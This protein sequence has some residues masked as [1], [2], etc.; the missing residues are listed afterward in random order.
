[1]IFNSLQ[2]FIFLSVVSLV[3]YFSHQRFRKSV[4]IIASVIFIVSFSFSSLI[5]V[6]LSS[7]LNFYAA[8]KSKHKIW[9]YT[10]IGL[11]IFLILFFN[12]V[13]SV[14]EQL[15]V[16]FKP[17][18][19]ELNQF[20]VAIG[21]SFYT[22]Q[23]I[24]YL[25]DVRRGR[26]VAEKDFS[27]FLL[28][29]FYFPK[30]VCGPIATYQEIRPQFRFLK[31]SQQNIEG[32][33]NRMLFGYFKKI[34]LADR[35]APAVSSVFDFNDD[36]AGF[37]I[38]TAGLIF[39]MQLYF[40]FS[41]YCDIAVGVSRIFGINLIENF[42]FP[43]RSTSITDFWRKWH[44]SLIHFFTHYV[45]YPIA[46]KLRKYF[47]F[48][49]VVAIIVTFTLSSL[50]HGIGVT[51]FAWAF[52]HMTFLCV[53]LFFNQYGN[54][55]KFKSNNLVKGIQILAV[56]TLVTISNV[57]FRAPNNESI[58]HIIHQLNLPN[59]CIPK[60]WL[61]DF[62]APLAQGGHQIQLFNFYTSL[63]LVIVFLLFERR[64]FSNFNSSKLNYLSVFIMLILIF[65][66]GV[67]GNSSRFIYMQF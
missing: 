58:S 9:F 40:D 41:G 44:K 15:H 42:D 20:L 30:L 22:I 52:C 38:I 25:I 61:A 3:Y 23:H 16:F 35:L 67:F 33:I 34:V 19:F 24:A 66:F 14:S 45:Y 29:S 31:P 60:D 10:I 18:G 43:L 54:N 59:N 53:E 49:T 27:I 26:I 56:I 62:I 39:T 13:T 21:L 36:L 64:L 28:A 2:F 32:G 8:Q 55:F 46:F 51:F 4:L 7:L 11:N 50:W 65:V 37:T 47:L 48:S 57:F 5:V 6:L 63:L 12:Y 17:I 1:M